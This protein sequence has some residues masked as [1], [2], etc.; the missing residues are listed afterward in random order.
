VFDVH[1][2]PASSM[3]PTSIPTGTSKPTGT[4]GLDTM[5]LASNASAASTS[6]VICAGAL[7]A[8]NQIPTNAK[9]TKSRARVLVAIAASM[10]GT[11]PVYCGRRSLPMG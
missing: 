2:G 10:E 4:S 3:G 5:S 11:L 6:S 1:G 8:A 9:Q 7:Q